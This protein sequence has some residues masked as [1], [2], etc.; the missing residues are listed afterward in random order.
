[1]LWMRTKRTRPGIWLD[2][3]DS[4]G[5]VMHSRWQAWATRSAECWRGYRERG[6]TVGTK[7]LIYCQR[8]FKWVVVLSLSVAQKAPLS[9]ELHK[10]TLYVFATVS[11][12]PLRILAVSSAW[13]SAL[14]LCARG[15]D[16]DALTGA[17]MEGQ[18]QISRCKIVVVGD[19]QCGK[20]ALLHV[21]AKDSYPEVRN[22]GSLLESNWS[23]E[24]NLSNTQTYL[25][26]QR[27]ALCL[28]C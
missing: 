20:T 9:F 5:V 21:F 26:T 14:R 28:R 24:N 7:R 16:G 25:H 10:R 11:R 22:R 15:S 23:E 2:A 3:G 1:M 13:C 4:E 12:S 17:L 6:V 19:T 18:G 8:R 27:C